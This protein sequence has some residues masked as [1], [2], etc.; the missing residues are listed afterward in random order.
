MKFWKNDKISKKNIYHIPEVLD[1]KVDA[2]IK[3]YKEN[4]VKDNYIYVE[5]NSKPIEFRNLIEKMAVWYEFRYPDYEVSRILF[6]LNQEKLVDNNMFNDNLYINE[7]C[8]EFSEARILDWD[9]FYNFDAF[10][11]LLSI[12]ERY[13]FRKYQYPSI[14]Y[15]S[16]KTRGRHL[17]LDENGIVEMDEFSFKGKNC[18]GKHIK[19][20]VGEAKE[21][22]IEFPEDSEMIQTIKDAENKEKLRDKLLNAVM[23]RIIERGG[24]RIGAYRAYLFAKEFKRNLDIPLMYGI[25]LSD[26]N[27]RL[28]INRYLKDGGNSNLKCY[29]GYGSRKNKYESL[30]T[31]SINLLLKMT[32]HNAKDFYTPEEKELGQKLVNILSRKLE[33]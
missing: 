2:I 31:I 19:E 13:Y 33:K 23:Y 3:W 7:E 30:L 1:D 11:K 18:E 26:P 20:V 8:D 12:N 24:N 5:K 32:P 22:G 14:V 29:I 4:M 28:F 16:L 10:L 27:L 21:K 6:S 15:F 9:K 25:D 17:H